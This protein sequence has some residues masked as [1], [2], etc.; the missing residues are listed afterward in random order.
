MHADCSWFNKTNMFLV[1]SHSRIYCLY[2]SMH[3]CKSPPCKQ[4][5]CL[6]I[7][8]SMCVYTLSMTHSTPYQVPTQRSAPPPLPHSP[9]AARSA[10][11]PS[12]HSSQNPEGTQQGTPFPPPELSEERGAGGT[13]K[14]G[15]RMQRFY[16]GLSLTRGRQ[17][18][19]SSGKFTAKT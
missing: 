12:H 7:C 18:P 10:H 16:Q 19:V 13:E 8:S 17:P 9:P 11:T 3:M 15:E 4:A 6:P 2:S 1:H 14:G 5:A